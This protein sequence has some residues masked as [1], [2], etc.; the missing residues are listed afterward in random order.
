MAVLAVRPAAATWPEMAWKLQAWGEGSIMGAET[1]AGGVERAGDAATAACL[2]CC[3]ALP[4]VK[5]YSPQYLCL[6]RKRSHLQ[7]P[8]ISAAWAPHT[9]IHISRS[10][11]HA[12]VPGPS[13]CTSSRRCALCR[14]GQA[15]RS[16][17][18]S[19]M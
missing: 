7:P 9:F 16:H 3:A 1:Q 18:K 13:P 19:S 10:A 5:R 14:S 6:P 17:L 2:L 4:A 11:T 12:G 15:D 8:N